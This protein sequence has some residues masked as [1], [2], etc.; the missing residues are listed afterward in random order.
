MGVGGGGG[1]YKEHN[2]SLY[3]KH[4]TVGATPKGNIY[5]ETRRFLVSS[6]LLLFL[7]SHSLGQASSSP[8]YR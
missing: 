6:S 7:L 2:Y 3:A 1:V 8:R 4:Y 5:E